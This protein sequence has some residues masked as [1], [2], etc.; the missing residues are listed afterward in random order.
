MQFACR[1]LLRYLGFT[2]LLVPGLSSAHD[3]QVHGSNT[4]GATLAPM[5]MTGFLQQRTG[6]S[7]LATPTGTANETVLST[8]DNGTPLSVL[9]AAHGTSTGFTSMAAAQADIWAASRRIKDS[10]VASMASRADMTSA[11]SEHIIAIDG[12]A[13][14]VHPSNPVNE[15]TIETLAKIFA[16]EITNWSAVGGADRAIQVYARDEQSGTWDTF[17]E[18]VLAGKYALA[19]S[20][21]RYESN[22]E[23]SEDVSGDPAGIGF[24]GFAS[25]GRS[26]LLAIAD[27]TAPALKPS[28]LSVATEDYPLSRRLYLYTPGSTGSPLAQAFIRYAQSQAGQEIVARSGFFSQNPFAVDPVYDASVPETFKRLTERYQRLSVNFRFAEGHTKLDNK[29]NRDLMRVQEYLKQSGKTG[30]DLM[31][32]GF[33][34]KR[35]HE[36]RAQM[37][38]ELRARSASKAL[39]ELGTVVQGHT[40]YG[41]YMPV[42]S[43]GGESGDQRNGRVEVWVRR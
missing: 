26:K 8:T 2:L 18:L 38:S 34:D 41:H 20:A 1:R 31:L 29:A 13:I 35:S 10:E 9:V 14:L 3:L 40:G 30:S 12:L 22:D 7:V 15:L 17:K 6:Q 33:A 43:A 4:I 36:L 16:G 25:V 23:L 24:A 42:G 21:L 5:L 27:G 39:R 11:E 32:I 37:I 28:E 19:G